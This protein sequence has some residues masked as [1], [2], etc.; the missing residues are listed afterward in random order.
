MERASFRFHSYQ[1]G[2]LDCVGRKNT[3]RPL[4]PP[5][6]EAA[7]FSSTTKKDMATSYSR[8]AHLAAGVS[9]LI[10]DGPPR[11]LLDR[12]APRCRD[13]P[14]VQNSRDSNANIEANC[15]CKLYPKPTR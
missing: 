3:F 11:P 1:L 9:M 10:E 5:L 7:M 8:S 12:R 14:S 2:L 4:R 6:M 15:G 13:A